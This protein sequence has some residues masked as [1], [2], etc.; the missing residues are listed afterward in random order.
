MSKDYSVSDDPAWQPY[1]DPDTGE[2]VTL[3]PAQCA[4]VQHA[5]QVYERVINIELAKGTNPNPAFSVEAAYRVYT[6]TKSCLMGRL[7]YD[8]K[9][10]LVDAPPVVMA[11]PDYS[12]E[13]SRD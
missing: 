5:L 10:P 13:V 12:V 6:V 1:R 11:A 3:T 2:V 7:L 9:A 4:A 8:G